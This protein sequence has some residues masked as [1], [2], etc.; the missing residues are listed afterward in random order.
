MK[1]EEFEGSEYMVVGE[2]LDGERTL[3]NNNEIVFINENGD[4]IDTDNVKLDKEQKIFLKMKNDY[5]NLLKDATFENELTDAIK[6][7]DNQ[8]DDYYIDMRYSYCNELAFGI[9]RIAFE[10]YKQRHNLK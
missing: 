4:K 8:L 10:E 2:G 3:I 7:I 9:L 5:P 6:T 1:F